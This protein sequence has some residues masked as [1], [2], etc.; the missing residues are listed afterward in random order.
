MNAAKSGFGI[1]QN[2]KTFCPRIFLKQLLNLISAG[3]HHLQSSRGKTVSS[4]KMLTNFCFLC[5]LNKYKCELRVEFGVRF[6]NFLKLVKS[7]RNI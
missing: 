7:C 2:P 3:Q 4:G 1:W 5:I 6:D